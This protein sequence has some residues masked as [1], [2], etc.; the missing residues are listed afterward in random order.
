MKPPL[1]VMTT[2]P[3]LV[4]EFSKNRVAVPLMINN[5]LVAMV[6]GFPLKVPPD[7]LNWPLMVTG[8]LRLIVPF[9]KLTMSL[10]AGTPEGVQ[11]V[12]LNQS[13]LTEP[14]QVRLI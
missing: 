4:S 7:Q 11:L 13:L 3:A 10:D 8:A 1:L 2:V 14:F 12:A 9:V 6:K 5:P